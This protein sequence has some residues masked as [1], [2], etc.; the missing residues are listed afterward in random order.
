[1]G[2]GC[3]SYLWNKLLTQ[4]RLQSPPAPANAEKAVTVPQL[5]AFCVLF[6]PGEQSPGNLSCHLGVSFFAEGHSLAA[7]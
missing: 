6:A 5:Y 4:R 3:R 1:M 2:V 7:L